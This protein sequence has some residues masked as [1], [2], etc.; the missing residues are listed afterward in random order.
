MHG[1]YFQQVDTIIQ[2]LYKY[3]LG[4][5]TKKRTVYLRTTRVYFR[6]HKIIIFA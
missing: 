2:Q 6:S 4:L 1:A 3:I 5:R